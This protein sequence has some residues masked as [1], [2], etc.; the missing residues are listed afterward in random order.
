LEFLA[1]DGEFVVGRDLQ[2]ACDSLA[3]PAGAAHSQRLAHLIDP[4]YDGLV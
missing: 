3:Q 1:S 4:R 2:A